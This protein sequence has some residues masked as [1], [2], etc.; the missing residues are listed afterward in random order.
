MRAAILT[1]P[2]TPLAIREIPTP[3]PGTG[4]VVVDI[5]ACGVC[6]S[7]LHAAAGDYPTALPITLGHEVAAMHPELGPVLVYACWGCRK[8]DCWACSSN[9]EMICPNATEA[10]LFRDGGYA[11]KMLV[12][13]E[14]YLIP[15]GDLDPARTAPLACGG[16]T[17][18]RAV[19]HTLATLAAV[20]HP[21]ALVIGAGGLGQFGLQF[22]KI[23]SDAEVVVVDASPEKRALAL[24]L[25]ADA[26]VAPGEVEGTFN[27][28]IDF[29]G[30]EQTLQTARDHVAR[31]GI[32][33]VVGLYGGA[34]P[35][36]FG[37]VPHEARFMSS[38][39]GTRDQLADLIALAQQHDLHS[40]IEVVA[41][42][43]AQVAHDRLH[44]GEVSGRFVIVPG[45]PT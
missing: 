8:P 11:E 4:G 36:G 32:A 5:L 45:A 20:P 17:A 38:I 10:G 16:L 42:E 44:R 15:I 7:D 39:W 26:A 22:A 25:G 9:Q 33:V 41:L 40:E 24:T 12:P 27:A 13:D 18:Y 31:Q 30:A 29:V 37:L 23:R 6:H 21:R 35:F 19:D 28:V 3:T 43:D 34:V 14:C 2:G 1:A